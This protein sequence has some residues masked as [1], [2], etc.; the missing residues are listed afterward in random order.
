VR[1]RISGKKESRRS[2]QSKTRLSEK[3]KVGGESQRW[4]TGKKREQR[5][6]GDE[7]RHLGSD[8]ANWIK[9]GEN[10]NRRQKPISGKRGLGKLGC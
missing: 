3:K 6:E 7:N 5:Y 8:W 1:E 2:G 4:G 10:I 9:G